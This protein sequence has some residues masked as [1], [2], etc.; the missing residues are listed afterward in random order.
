MNE[1]IPSDAIELSRYGY[2][3]YGII[4]VRIKLFGKKGIVY[5]F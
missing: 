1:K 3:D 2:S 5:A 4:T